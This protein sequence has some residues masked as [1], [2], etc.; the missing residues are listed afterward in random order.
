MCAATS[1]SGA[2]SENRKVEPHR[3]W[4]QEVAAAVVFEEFAGHLVDEIGQDVVAEVAVE[5]LVA[6]GS[7]FSVTPVAKLRT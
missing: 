3:Q 2:T 6:A 5:E 7:W 1:A 4:R